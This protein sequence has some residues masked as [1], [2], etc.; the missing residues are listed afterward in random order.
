MA[1]W[2][3]KHQDNFTFTFTFTVTTHHDFAL[4]IMDT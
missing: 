3:V 4:Y 2:L 1:W